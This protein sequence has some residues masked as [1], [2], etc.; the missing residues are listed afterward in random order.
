[1]TGLNPTFGTHR[2]TPQTGQNLNY[3]SEIKPGRELVALACADTA[4]ESLRAG[5]RYAAGYTDPA[6]CCVVLKD[7]IETALR[8]LDRI[9]TDCCDHEAENGWAL[10]GLPIPGLDDLDDDYIGD[11][12]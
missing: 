7:Y 10:N 4:A 3:C 12:A 1:M 2:V 6:C 11:A 5:L 8:A 9:S